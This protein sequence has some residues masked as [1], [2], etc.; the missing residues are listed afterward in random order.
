[1]DFGLMA[2][3][4]EVIHLPAKR[5]KPV[6]WIGQREICGGLTNL[7]LLSIQPKRLF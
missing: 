5:G 1:V 2:A 3:Q 7:A 6:K 4:P